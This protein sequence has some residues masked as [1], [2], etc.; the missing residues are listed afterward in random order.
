MYRFIYRYAA[1]DSEHRATQPFFRAVDLCRYVYPS[2]FECGPSGAK[3]DNPAAIKS[4]FTKFGQSA[5]LGRN[6]R[7]KVVF[8]AP[9]GPAMITMRL[10]CADE[11]MIFI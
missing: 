8:P 3:G 2:C 1:P 9:F 4:A 10:M 11:F 6:S 5:S 7:A